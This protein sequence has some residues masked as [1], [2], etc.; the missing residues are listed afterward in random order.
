MCIRGFCAQVDSRRALSNT[1][2]LSNYRISFEEEHFNS[3][4]NG[5]YYPIYIGDISALLSISSSGKQ[6]SSPVYTRDE[7]HT[8]KTKIHH[9]I[10]QA[11]LFH[12]GYGLVRTTLDTLLLDP[13]GWSSGSSAVGSIVTGKVKQRVLY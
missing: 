3:T 11:D 9:H 13:C 5:H 1:S 6:D 8:Q 12:P 4:G 10:S 7:S 2:V